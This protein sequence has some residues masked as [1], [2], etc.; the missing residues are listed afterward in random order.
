MPDRNLSTNFQLI[1]LEGIMSESKKIFLETA[2]AIGARLCRDALWHGDC[3]NWLGDSMEYVGN[4]WI[5]AHRACGPELYGGTSGIAVFLAR[6]LD[7]TSERIYRTTAEGGIQ[8]ALTQLENIPSSARIAFYSGL[9][10]VAYAAITIGELLADEQYVDNGLHIIENLLHDDAN[11][12]GLDVISG[13]AGAIPA[14]LYFHTRYQ[15]DFLIDLAIRHGEHLLNSARKRDFGW[16]WNTLNLPDGDGGD[17]LTGLSHGTAGI[18]RALLE[19]YNFT[20]EKRFLTAA[21]QAFEYERHWFSPEHENWPDLRNFAQS[22]LSANEGP[23]YNV[24]WCH[25]APGIGLSRVRANEISGEEIYRNEAETAIQTTMKSLSQTQNTGQGNY[26]LCHGSAGNTELIIYSSQVFNNA[27]YK[28]FAEQTGI[29]GYEIYEKNR[30]P[31]PCGVQ[32]GG[33]TPNLMLGLAG[34]GYFYLRLYDPI[35]I[36]SVLIIPVEKNLDQS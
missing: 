24:A 27:N 34:I 14:L 13:S 10:G 11:E 33:E 7:L 16:S 3:C 26:S 8:Q 18:A 22:T 17:D 2:N 19:L 4:S 32:G 35:K 20:G 28:S 5:V 1:K 23:T 6:L 15:K 9:T 25:G 36:P 12:Q 29:R 30:I 31:W 21:E